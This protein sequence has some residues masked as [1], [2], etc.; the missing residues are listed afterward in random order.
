MF[1][2]NEYDIRNKKIIVLLIAKMYIQLIVW[3]N[4]NN[5]LWKINI[6]KQLWHHSF[7]APEGSGLLIPLDV[8]ITIVVL[9]AILLILLL[10]ALFCCMRLRQRKQ[11]EKLDSS[12]VFATKPPV[13]TTMYP[14]DSSVQTI[15]TGDGNT[16][17]IIQPRVSMY[18]VLLL[19]HQHIL[20]FY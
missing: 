17:Q 7:S 8:L 4:Q 18:N 3:M 12:D 15:P 1:L 14:S 2:R 6:H 19:E 10:L 11:R 20:Y 16:I 9:A 5:R 13:Q